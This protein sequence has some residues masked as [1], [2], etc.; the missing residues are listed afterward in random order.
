M[1]NEILAVVGTRKI[2]R[3]HLDMLMQ[4]LAPQ[5]AAQFNSEEG[6]KRLLEELINQELL[7][8][9]AL[10]EG[11]D[12]SEE[13][14]LEVKRAE[15][16]ILKQMAMNKLLAGASVQEGEVLNYFNNNKPMF[17][18]PD[19]IRA[20]HILLASEKD[21]LKVLEEIEKGL[22]FEKAAEKYSSCPSKEQGGDLGY[23]S[24]GSMVPEFE[25]AAFRLNVG[26][27]S[28]PVKTQFGY[29]I[30]KVVDKKPGG[31][32][33]FDEVK[34]QIWQQLLMK[35]QQD[36]YLKKTSELRK[37]FQVKLNNQ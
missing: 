2:T 9:D 18:N 36:L 13:Y 1:N 7:Y 14:A 5:V 10:E 6:R 37:K 17:K 27:I 32:K 15:E 34:N 25:E 24:L 19:T 12:K 23:F 4:G 21:A 33:T 20:S 35:K 3:Q 31:E 8:L 30:I 29:H 16:T 22:S 11:L 28:A 26:E